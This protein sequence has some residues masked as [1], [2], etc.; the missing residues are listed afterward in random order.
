MVRSLNAGFIT[1]HFKKSDVLPFYGMSCMDGLGFCV[2]YAA[3]VPFHFI[4]SGGISIC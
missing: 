3:A 4:L 2:Q 1:E